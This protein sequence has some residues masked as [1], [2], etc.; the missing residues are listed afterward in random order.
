MIRLTA[1]FARGC[2]ALLAGIIAAWLSGAAVRAAAPARGLST[3][4]ARNVSA[5][6]LNA[7]RQGSGTTAQKIAALNY[8]AVDIIL[9]A[10]TAL[11]PDGSLD[12]NYGSTEIYRPLLIPQ[13]HA[14]S[15]SVLMS[16]NGCARG[17]AG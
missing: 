11:N 3:V 5:G 4:P 17:P 8:E 1:Y 12:H 10:F 14:H 6:Y 15:R 13:A 16:M 9:L 7:I 2:S